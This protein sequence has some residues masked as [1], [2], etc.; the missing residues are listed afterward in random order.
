MSLI[1]GAKRRRVATVYVSDRH[2]S[3]VV[4]DCGHTTTRQYPMT[5]GRR[6]YCLDC[7]KMK[8]TLP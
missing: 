7:A 1:A 4:L 6:A 5:P 3:W 2:Y 8:E